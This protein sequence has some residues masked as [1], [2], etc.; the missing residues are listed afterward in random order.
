[1]TPTICGITNR[2]GP[3]RPAVCEL[4]P[5]PARVLIRVHEEGT[6]CDERR[7]RYGFGQGQCEPLQGRVVGDC[8]QESGC[9]IEMRSKPKRSDDDNGDYYDRD[10]NC[11]S[12][13]LEEIVTDA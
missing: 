13:R 1:M 5:G 7:N 12:D 8:H 9:I 3:V 11:G 2:S 10:R 6:D 4:A